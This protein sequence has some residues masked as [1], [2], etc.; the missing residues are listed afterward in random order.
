MLEDVRQ[1]LVQGSG[2][3]I[4]AGCVS[5][6]DA[7]YRVACSQERPWNR[8]DRLRADGLCGPAISVM[9]RS[10]RSSSSDSSSS[11]NT[12]SVCDAPLGLGLSA[13]D[14][15]RCHQANASMPNQSA[16]QRRQAANQCTNRGW[17]VPSPC[18]S[19]QRFRPL[20][21]GRNTD[22]LAA[23]TAES[24]LQRLPQRRWT[25]RRGGSR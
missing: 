4:Y 14:A 10:S 16:V 2:G 24:S 6:D 20:E 5:P 1:C 7:R 8:P 9:H 21:R 3:R 22:Q 18:T 12:A 25:K 23:H 13:F 17:C 15:L 19:L 11:S